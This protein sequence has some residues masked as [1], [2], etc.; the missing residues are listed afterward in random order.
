MLAHH[1]HRREYAA[2]RRQLHNYGISFTAYLMKCLIS[3][4]WR[5]PLFVLKMP[6]GIFRLLGPKSKTQQGK[7]STY[8]NELTWVERRGWLV[9]PFA[10]LRSRRN[11]SRTT[12]SQHPDEALSRV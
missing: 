5:I 11:L 6:Y 4:P 3:N 10:Y 12:A 9:G 1:V 7:D 8:P 2:L